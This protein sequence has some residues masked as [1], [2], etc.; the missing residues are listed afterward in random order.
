MLKIF[1]SAQRASQVRVCDLAGINII[2]QGIDPYC[3]PY[4]KFEHWDFSKPLRARYDGE[5]WICD[6]WNQNATM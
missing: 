6:L 4:I 2:Q 5:C 3:V 1:N